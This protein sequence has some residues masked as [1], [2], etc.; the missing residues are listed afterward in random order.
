MNERMNE[1]PTRRHAPFAPNLRQRSQEVTEIVRARP[2]PSSD[3]SVSSEMTRS[4]RLRSSVGQM[5]GPA[6]NH[7]ARQHMAVYGKTR[8]VTAGRR[9][10]FIQQSIFHGNKTIT[11]RIL[12][13]YGRMAVG[14][15]RLPSSGPVFFQFV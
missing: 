8:R 14:D 4:K 13:E 9:L 3:R 12:F 6:P 10:I 1:R 2:R 11:S 7:S 15:S 5:D